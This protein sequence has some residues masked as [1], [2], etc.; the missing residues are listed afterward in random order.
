MATRCKTVEFAFPTEQATLAKGTRRELPILNIHLPETGKVFRS[1]ILEMGCTDELSDKPTNP[2]GFRVEITLFPADPDSLT[3]EEV[4][5]NT[6][7][8]SVYHISRDVTGYFNTNWT[9]TSMSVR[10]ATTVDGNTT[11]NHWAKLRITYEYDEQSKRQLKTIWYPIESTRDLLTDSYQ[12]VGGPQAIPAITGGASILPEHNITVRQVWIELIGNQGTSDATDFSLDLELDGHGIEQTALYRVEAALA[13]PGWFHAIWDV[14]NQPLDRAQ[15]LRAKITGTSNRVAQL[16]GWV[17]IT[18]EYV[19]VGTTLVWNS[20]LLPAFDAE[21]QHGSTTSARKTL[22][23]KELWIEEPATISIRPSQVFA[24]YDDNALGS[25]ITLW[26]G[27]QSPRSFSTLATGGPMVIGHRFDADGASGLG[28]TLVRGRNRIKTH[29]IS[30]VADAGSVCAVSGFMIVNY[31][32]GVSPAGIGAHNQTRHFALG[33]FG[34]KSTSI[35]YSVDAYASYTPTLPETHYFLNAVGLQATWLSTGVSQQVFRVQAQRTNDEGPARDGN[36]WASAYHGAVVS[37]A[38]QWIRW[39]TADCTNLFRRWAGD[40]DRARMDIEADRR[41]MVLNTAGAWVGTFGLLVTYHSIAMT[42]RGTVSGA[43]DDGS[44][45]LVNLS[46]D[47][48]GEKVLE[49]ETSA[50]GVYEAAWYDDTEAL[51]ADVHQD[52]AHVGRSAPFFASE[53]RVAADLPEWDESDEPLDTQIFTTPGT[54]TWSKPTNF[55]ARWVKVVCIGAGGGGGGGGSSATVPR[56]GGCGGGGGAHSCEV[57]PAAQLPATVNGVVG[58]GGSGGPGGTANGSDGAVGGPSYF[59]SSS[60]PYVYAGGGGGGRRGL[61]TRESGQG[62]GGGGRGSNG[63]TGSS[64]LVANEGGPGLSVLDSNTLAASG[65]TG[66]RG[67]F[68]ASYAASAEYGGGG[69]GGCSAS[70]AHPG[71][72]SLFG[73][74]GGGA[75]GG[76]NSAEPIDPGAGGAS[77]GFTSGNDGAPGTSGSSPTAGSSGSNA[78]GIR[79]CGSGGGG[80]GGNTATGNGAAGGAGGIPGGA[81]GGGGVGSGTGAV[82]GK[83]GAGARGEVRVYTW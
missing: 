70:S 44:G 21:D 64:S 82:G 5:V 56:I 37:A 67:G 49:V 16:C 73:G 2:T 33:Y 35:E 10:V 59:G 54:F 43:A 25:T 34:G 40:P 78:D 42:A 6:G 32:S 22:H 7:E 19:P 81:G 58:D 23:V 71:G 83:G 24:F 55:T 50:G 66:C 62:G 8:S 69:G 60:V 41:W 31:T 26:V 52:D 76:S 30:D 13:T 45:L 80:G 75:G 1:V 36:G 4:E 53:L 72:S 28:S 11:N 3:T 51:V 14:T 17:G 57:F 15:A 12:T 9:G 68:D 63:M 48:T 20:L 74:G 77:G 65:G 38:E 46:R 29:H 18:Y 47:A 39:T 27:G 79:R 61:N